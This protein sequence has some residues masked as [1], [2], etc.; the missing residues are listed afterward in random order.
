MI[1]F[2]N[3]K[4]NLG[5]HILRK[6]ED[7]YHDLQTVFYPLALKDALEVVR[8]TA[9]LTDIE[10][11]SSGL[12]VQG[13]LADNICL[14]AYHLLK[15]D[16]RDLPPVKL[17][18]HKTIPMGAGLGGGSADGA[19]TLLLLNQKFNLGLSEESLL[20]YALQ[21]GSDC[22]F[23]IRN[24]PCFASGRGEKMED[25]PLDLSPY[26]F[27]LIN[28]GIHVNTGWA[29]SQIR[30]SDKKPSLKDIVQLPPTE[31]KDRLT[32]DFEAPVTTQHPEIGAITTTLYEKG[33]IYAAMTGS[34]S[35]VFGLFPK[36]VKP[37][38]TFPTH[39]FVSLV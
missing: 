36:D 32:N 39:Y 25:L 31:W 24:R 14:K 30:P 8:H 28:P 18:L 26:N 9:P 7:G 35:T 29:F 23:F 13:D 20:Q 17:H 34:G 27:V 1:V 37:A 21:L 11:S 12:P 33:A 16:F 5:L 10:Y 38:F 22:P 19:F 15:Q 3:C 6:R 2:P 4:I